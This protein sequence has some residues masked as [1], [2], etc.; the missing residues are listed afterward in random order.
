MVGMSRSVRGDRLTG[1]ELIVLTNREGE[2]WYRSQ[3]PD[4]LVAWIDG[5]PSD[6]DQRLELRYVKVTCGS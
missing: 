4:S 6:P 2:V 3:G 5:G 1:H